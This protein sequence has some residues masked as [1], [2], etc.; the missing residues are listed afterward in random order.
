MKAKVSGAQ[1]FGK[2]TSA[3][4]NAPL[5]GVSVT[6][7]MPGTPTLVLS[8][9]SDGGFDTRVAAGEVTITYA[10]SGFSTQT[11]H[12]LVSDGAVVNAGTIAMKAKQ[13]L[14]TM[15]GSVVDQD[16]IAIAGAKLTVL[17][18]WRWRLFLK[19]FVRAAVPGAVIC[20]RLR[21]AHLPSIDY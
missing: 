19:R 9:G 7:Q 4:I 14:S 18:Q 12:A 6:L 8:S 1:I 3:Q 16:G 2:V 5:S 10:L 20:V 13:L 11:Q 21:R 15:R 17:G